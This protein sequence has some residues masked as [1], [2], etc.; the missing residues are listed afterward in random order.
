LQIS[1]S[2]RQR[3]RFCLA[4]IG[5]LARYFAMDDNANRFIR[6]AKELFTWTAALGDLLHRIG[7]A[8]RMSSISA[9]DKLALIDSSKRISDLFNKAEQFIDDERTDDLIALSDQLRDEIVK[10]NVILDRLKVPDCPS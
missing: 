2:Q 8:T 3:S 9:A 6:V 1:R 10:A 4:F 5:P 7:E